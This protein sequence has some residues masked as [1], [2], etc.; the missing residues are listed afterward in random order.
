MGKKKTKKNLE[1]TGRV[2]FTP[3]PEKAIIEFK[4]G[5]YGYNIPLEVKGAKPSDRYRVCLCYDSRVLADGVYPD[6]ETG[7]WVTDK[8]KALKRGDVIQVKASELSKPKDP[9]FDGE[10]NPLYYHN[11]W[12]SS[13]RQ[14]EVLSSESSRPRPKVTK[15]TTRRPRG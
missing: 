5:D 10:G 13:P 2:M 9:Q 3:D 12:V 6:S 15:K 1:I 4:D 8:S 14:I 11:Y 7:E